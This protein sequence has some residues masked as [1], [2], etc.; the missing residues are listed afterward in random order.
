MCLMLIYKYMFEAIVIESEKMGLTTCSFWFWQGWLG[1]A[2]AH[3]M[4]ILFPF[5]SPFQLN[6]QRP[7]KLLQCLPNKILSSSWTCLIW[8]LFW[9]SSAQFIIP[10]KVLGRL[11][12]YTQKPSLE[13]DPTPGKEAVSEL[14]TSPCEHVSFLTPTELDC[15]QAHNLVS[16]L[17]NPKKTVIYQKVSSQ[18]VRGRMGK[19]MIG[20]RP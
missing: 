10:R 5:L 8:T 20:F 6:P 15:T 18:N 12:E 7:N 1:L 17:C 3:W 2:W 13:Y 19:F 16:G 11:C 9:Y 4:H 14:T